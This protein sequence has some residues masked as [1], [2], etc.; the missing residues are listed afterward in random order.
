MKDLLGQIANQVTISFR[1]IMNN[2]KAQLAT[3]SGLIISLTIIS[4]SSML[5]DSYRY[6]LIEEFFFTEDY[7]EYTGDI[8]I[9]LYP[10]PEY[11]ETIWVQDYSY[12]ESLITE[13]FEKMRY[14]DH[15]TE[16]Q[17]LANIDLRMLLDE[18]ALYQ[19][20]WVSTYLR[21]IDDHVYP[22][23]E[24]YLIPGGR[25]P[26]NFSEMIIIINE[27][28]YNLTIGSEIEIS[29]PPAQFGTT[30]YN[31]T[32]VGAVNYSDILTKGFIQQYLSLS[33][34]PFEHEYLGEDYEIP[35]LLVTYPQYVIDLIR[36]IQG[37]KP[38]LTITKIYGKIFLDFSRLDVYNLG[39]ERSS[40]NALLA[41]LNDYTF[42]DEHNYVDITDP[43]D[44]IKAFDSNKNRGQIL[45]VLLLLIN[46]PV[47]TI[48]LYLINYS[49]G[50]IKRQKRET[51]GIIKTRG[52][53]WQQI[54]TMLV[55]ELIF[56]MLIA[57]S[58]GLIFGYFIT[59][60]LIRSTGF[61]DFSGTNIE[62]IVTSSMILNIIIFA[63]FFV[64]LLNTTKLIEYCRMSI[65]DS[66][67][68]VEN[69]VPFW[70]RYYI[71]I[72][73]TF[74]GI[75]GFL[76]ISNINTILGTSGA[77][78]NLVDIRYA[79]FLLLGVPAPF[80][81]FFGSIFL[82]ARFFP[83]LIDKLA[84]I[85][86]KRRG[87][88][89]SFSLRNVV[90]H[91]QS[92]RQAVILLTLAL[93]Y[94]IISASLAFSIDE[95]KKVSY[96]Y[97][98]G[99]DLS[100]NIDWLSSSTIDYLT[101]NLSG[102]SSISQTLSGYTPSAN[103][104][105]FYRF[106]FVDPE[107]Y[108]DTAFFDENA[109]KLS[110]SLPTLMEKLD[111]NKTILLFDG[112]MNTL[113]AKINDQIGFHFYNQTLRYTD[114]EDF[115]SFTVAGTFGYWPQQYYFPGSPSD[116]I[117]AVGSLGMFD[118]LIKH[119][120]LALDDA[121]WLVDLEPDVDTKELYYTIFSYTTLPMD[122][123]ILNYQEYLSSMDRIF[124]L[125]VLNSAL[126]ICIAV[127]IISAL[128]F[129]IFTYLE[130][131]KEIGIERALGMTRM[132]TGKIFIIEGLT[133]LLFGMSIG[134][135]SSLVNTSF[136]LLVTQMGQ[137]VP[138]IIVD[139]PWL[140]IFQFCL[141]IFL[142]SVFSTSIL[143]YQSTRRDISRVLKVE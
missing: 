28:R 85:M 67:N 8:R 37:T 44:L 4:T 58:G 21:A 18:S 61:L 6:G 48:A 95:T 47:I 105:H 5:M 49:L 102:V 80:L 69:K 139:F 65:Q 141:L 110:S 137:T 27:D 3:L 82:V 70:K 36:Q 10:N 56:S 130:R 55:G 25:L 101:N 34:N 125:S 123:G 78:D 50:L 74:L 30:P 127:S 81:F 92:A 129:A 75:T 121:R 41:E 113:H 103:G 60:Y 31:I 24:S 40:F 135:V 77:N 16:Q 142:F 52:G 53:S 109:F 26:E 20:R 140:F 87:K 2:R 72:I 1:F 115:R 17:W 84:M 71:D 57:I 43:H 12:Y 100:I 59:T 136:F 32:V 39:E 7:D 51:I 19:D 35:Y 9:E 76:I 138:P 88:L 112:N 143:A 63:I 62:V 29:G 66:A 106:I 11:G 131:G 13:S 114:S 120:Y 22:E 73:S 64:I 108:V 79:I 126:V 132:Q 134:L 15:L 98:T 89:G 133:I 54:T 104:L 68:P 128:M 46:I 90:R 107:T 86:W 42:T 96:Y 99:A 117:L 97:D 124:A 119:K 38:L 122:T 45:Q 116:H 94:S 91:K 14:G 33:E 118:D 111:D 83:N 93:S 23:L